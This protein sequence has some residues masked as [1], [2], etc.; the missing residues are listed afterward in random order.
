MKVSGGNVTITK[1]EALQDGGSGGV[2]RFLGPIGHE[3]CPQ[4]SGTQSVMGSAV[5]RRRVLRVQG[6]RGLQADATAA[7]TQQVI[8]FNSNLMFTPVATAVYYINSKAEMA[9]NR[10]WQKCWCCDP[11]P[12]EG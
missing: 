8:F 4:R 5:L 9:G 11:L 1:S 3:G 7:V 10:P 6:S 2:A 12:A